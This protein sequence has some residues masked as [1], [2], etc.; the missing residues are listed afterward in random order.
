MSGYDLSSIIL[1]TIK[2]KE[3][4]P[5]TGI[6]ANNWKIEN[7]YDKNDTKQNSLIITYVLNAI[8]NVILFSVD[9]YFREFSAE[10]KI[11]HNYDS[12]DNDWYKY[13]EYGTIIL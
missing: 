2:F 5:E 7:W 4:P 8:E 13:V 11:Q 3:D 12:F 10:Y 1:Y 6:L 9:N